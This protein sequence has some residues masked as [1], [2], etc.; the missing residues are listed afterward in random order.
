M[1]KLICLAIV[2]CMLSL[3]ACGSSALNAHDEIVPSGQEMQIND[4]R[5]EVVGNL[6]QAVERERSLVLVTNLVG[7]APVRT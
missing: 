7:R 2:A 6:S 4:V 5:E 3:F 1:K